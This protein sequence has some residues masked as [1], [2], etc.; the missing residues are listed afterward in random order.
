MNNIIVGLDIGT[1]NVRVVI[2][3]YDENDS[4]QI[5]GIGVAPSTGLRSGVIVNIEAT[6]RAITSAIENAEMMSGCE[7]RS[8]FTG[9]GGTQ[10]DSLNSKGLVAVTSRN[11]NS[12]EI[13]QTDI[14]RVIE[15]A[16]A[17]SIPI[18]REILHVVPQMYIVD[19]IQ[20][21]KDPH[22]MIGVRL[23]IEVH[24][25]T[26]TLTTMQNIFKCATRL[27][28]TIDGVMLKTLAAAQSVLTDE[29]RE[30]GSIL[31]DLGGGST[32]V[33]VIAD[34]APICT[35]SVPIG[36]ILVTNDIS[37]V[38]GIATDTAERIKISD[39]CCWEPLLS[40]Y[41]EVVI[42]GVGGRPPESISR[43]D[44]CQIIQPRVEEILTMV[45][46]KIA[47]KIQK[48]QL[49]G[50][51]VLIGGGAKMSGII[52]LTSSVFETNAVRIGMVGNYGGI[53]DEYRSPDF[54]TAAG[55]VIANSQNS[56]ISG[57]KQS[58]KE[59]TAKK[60]GIKDAITG[61]FKEFF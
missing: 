59:Q 24:I 57:N 22:D 43:A 37:V 3:E 49:S 41:E 53:G 19:G 47:S 1:S 28:Y 30:L 54:A 58:E 38:R 14:D 34:G 42:R 16:R 20:R 4:L 25:I 2:G 48:R 35:D 26:A 45:K 18:D 61:F 55:L 50:N 5:T 39:G 13:N 31:I 44:I 21:T 11:K 33:I 60:H 7:V 52:E 27:G 36:G 8:C 23:E 51:V 9:I 46:Q 15:A 29:E 10:V 6:M 40:E 17:V 32:D 56:T 12:R